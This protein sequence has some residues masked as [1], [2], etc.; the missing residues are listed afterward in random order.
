MSWV[1]PVVGACSVLV[2]LFA[3]IFAW[4]V[5]HAHKEHRPYPE[6]TRRALFLIVAALSGVELHHVWIGRM[7]GWMVPVILVGNV[8][9]FLDAVLRFPIV[10]DVGT[11]FTLKQCFLVTGKVVCLSCGFEDL[12]YESMLWLLVVLV[13]NA[14][15]PLLYTLALPI[16]DDAV[17][18][19]LAAHDVVDVDLALRVVD[20]AMNRQRRLDSYGSLK[21]RVC[22][23][24]LKMADRSPLAEKAVNYSLRFPSSPMVKSSHKSRCV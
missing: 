19:R 15:F 23:T 7:Y 17:D 1:L 18:Q 5:L 2:V 12:N 14:F 4:H 9:G 13:V 16:D 20:L 8:W 24:A 10:Y 3:A 22:S 21:R 11:F 6:T